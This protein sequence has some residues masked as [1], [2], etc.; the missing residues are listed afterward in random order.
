[1]AV[2]AW[3]QMPNHAHLPWTPLEGDGSDVLQWI[4]PQ[5][6]MRTA[7]LQAA[8]ASPW[9]AGGGYDRLIWSWEAYRKRVEYSRWNPCHS[10]L[11][12]MPSDRTWSSAADRDI[13]PRPWTPKVRPPL[14]ELRTLNPG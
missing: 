8:G 5:S 9:L 6:A 13:A 4:K 14:L 7:A 2:H 11:S 3:V 1:M 10:S 12:R